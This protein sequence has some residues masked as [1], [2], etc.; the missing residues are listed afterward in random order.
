M[1]KSKDN[2]IINIKSKKRYLGDNIMK[3]NVNKISRK[4]F[5]ILIWMGFIFYLSHQPSSVSANQSGEFITMI[6][7]TPIIG[8]MLDSILTSS[9][10]EFIIRKSAHMF[11]Y[12]VL[13]IL[14]FTYIISIKNN[15]DSKYILKSIIITLSLVFLYACSDE[16][17]QLF[18]PGRS[19]EFRDVIV[20]TT[21][22]AI[23]TILIS[24]YYY[25]IKK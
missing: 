9:I 24:I 13:A 25:Y 21:G 11:L 10:G 8:S 12:F 2:I 5:L 19:G 1:L 14:T 15:R 20:D 16:M 18:I 23:G 7:N 6:L 22:G 4:I 17:H 3:E